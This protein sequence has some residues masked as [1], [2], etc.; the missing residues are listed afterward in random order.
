MKINYK[1][2]DK[3]AYEVL[4]SMGIRVYQD[5]LIA[6]YGVY[7]YSDQVK[8]SGNPPARPSVGKKMNPEGE[9]WHMD[10]H[11]EI[12]V[13]EDGGDTWSAP[14]PIIKGFM[15]NLGPSITSSGRLIMP[16]N[17][18]FAY[19]DDPSGTSSWKKAGLPRLPESFVD[20]P[21]GFHKACEYRGDTTHYYEGDFFQTN[22]NVIHMM[23][24]T[25]HSKLA[26]TESNDN[27]ESWSE[28]RWT[29]YTDARCRFDFGRLPDGRF[30]GLSTPQPESGRTPMV[31]AVSKDGEV[32]DKH[33]VLGDEKNR[34]PRMAGGHK[35]GR[36][37][38]PYMH[39]A[40]DYVFV[41]YSVVKEDIGIA[42][43]RLDDLEGL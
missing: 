4:T 35:G 36:Y 19:T 42:R 1:P 16:G 21:E 40:G 31:L 12:R 41:I 8:L 43:F 10:T 11:M 20:D 7:E 28:P 3:I 24:R 32:F 29:D 34:K 22:D 6:Y 13:S 27:G 15:A 17:I 23:L 5:K 30:F 9:Q 14:E 37:G 25:S 38:Y 2:P 18:S 26:V 39:I 33:I